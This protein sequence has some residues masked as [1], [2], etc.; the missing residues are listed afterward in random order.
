MQSEICKPPALTAQKHGNSQQKRQALGKGSHG[1]PVTA[2]L[3][4][5][6]SEIYFKS[7]I[8]AWRK[9]DNDY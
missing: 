5:W 4:R 1:N 7:I 9:I 2:M 8:R 3:L 6:R